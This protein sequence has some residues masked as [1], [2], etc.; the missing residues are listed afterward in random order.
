MGDQD[1]VPRQR[2]K[3]GQKSQI[4]H[5]PGIERRAKTPDRDPVFKH[6]VGR[7]KLDDPRRSER[8][9]DLGVRRMIVIAPAVKDRNASGKPG[10]QGQRGSPVVGVARLALVEVARDQ[11]QVGRVV[12]QNGN[13]ALRGSPVQVGEQSDPELHAARFDRVFGFSDRHALAPSRSFCIQY[14]RFPEK[15]Q[16]SLDKPGENTIQ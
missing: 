10:K 2:R 15:C 5:A 14:I 3:L 8:L 7:I 9:V 6:A 13:G 11:D 12:L 1:L 16:E 4:R